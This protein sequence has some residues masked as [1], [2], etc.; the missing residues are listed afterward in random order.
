M[1]QTRVND[2]GKGVA[3]AVKRLVDILSSELDDT[4]KSQLQLLHETL[5]ANLSTV[6]E[7]LGQLEQSVSA[8]LLDRGKT[9]QTALDQSISERAEAEEAAR[10]ALELRMKAKINEAVAAARSSITDEIAASYRDG[11]AQARSEFVRIAKE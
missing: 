4:G 2:A 3:A 8:E 6:E 11:Q 10:K 7:R 5:Q 1:D 9:M